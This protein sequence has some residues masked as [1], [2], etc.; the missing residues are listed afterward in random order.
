MVSRQSELVHHLLDDST[1]QGLPLT[2]LKWSLV[3]IPQHFLVLYLLQQLR[4][5]FQLQEMPP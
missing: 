1:Q 2:I 5:R 4:V 3:L